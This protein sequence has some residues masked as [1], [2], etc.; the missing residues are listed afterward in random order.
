MGLTCFYYVELY[1]IFNIY[2]EPISISPKINN[3]LAEQYDLIP[4]ALAFGSFLFHIEIVTHGPGP[5][6]TSHFIIDVVGISISVVNYLIPSNDLSRMIF[7][8]KIDTTNEITYS[9]LED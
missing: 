4:M 2:S 1:L 8:I 3:L 7:K 6:A 9:D 5:Y